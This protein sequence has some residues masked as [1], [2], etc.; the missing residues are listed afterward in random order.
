MYR[1][2]S[3]G[4]V[5]ITYNG[6][7]YIIEQL[8]SILKQSILPDDVI[9][10]DDMSSDSTCKIIEKYISDRHLKW[11]LKC[12][13]KNYGWCKNVYYALKECKT[14]LIFWADQDDVW[15]P[16]K[17]KALSDVAL[18][19]QKCLLAYSDRNYIDW[20]GNEL[21]SRKRN[22]T[23]KIKRIKGLKIPG[24]IPAVL[25]CSLC[26]KRELMGKLQDSIFENCDYNS[27]D[28]ILYYCARAFGSVLYINQPLFKRRIHENNLTV[29]KAKLK[30]NWKFDYE[31][32]LQTYRFIEIQL[33]TVCNYIDYF[34]Q[35]G[36]SKNKIKYLIYERRY[37]L[38]RL[39]YVNSKTTI[40]YVAYALL[41]CTFMDFIYTIWLD[42]CFRLY[43]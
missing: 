27:T 36:I 13:N 25:G 22:K 42:T 16:D 28:T 23:V 6:E 8:N 30:R 34:Y 7:R 33:K 5:V 40:S 37:L 32:N 15:L 31:K 41:Q 10:F 11:K 4:V 20:Q 26:L 38:E 35:S 14:D 12:R 39:K 2:K 29:S 19:D 9:I 18:S 43:K 21:Y 1:G 24:N 3:I 17:L